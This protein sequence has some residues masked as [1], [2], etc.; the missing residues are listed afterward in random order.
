MKTRHAHTRLGLVARPGMQR[1]SVRRWMGS[2][3]RALCT[4]HC[5]LARTQHQHVTPIPVVCRL[6]ATRHQQ[7]QSS[8]RK[9]KKKSTFLVPQ[10]QRCLDTQERDDMRRTGYRVPRA[11]RTRRRLWGRLLR[12]PP[13]TSSTIHDDASA[14][15]F[16]HRSS[17]T[18]TL[19]SNLARHYGSQ[20][21]S[22]NGG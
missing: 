22:H 2:G 11:Y 9:G 1:S 10:Q 17:C 13:Y 5:V 18:S 20:E 12:P 4:V 21:Q 3:G 7:Q 6:R 8:P 15:V 14:W 19:A 16:E